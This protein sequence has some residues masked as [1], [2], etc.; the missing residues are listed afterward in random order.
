MHGLLD[1]GEFPI[2]NED[3]DDNKNDDKDEEVELSD[4]EH[5]TH[6]LTLPF[7][8]RT[9]AKLATALRIGFIGCNI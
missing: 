4:D 3:G 2:D 7:L 5:I 9:C 8:G 6:F 1:I